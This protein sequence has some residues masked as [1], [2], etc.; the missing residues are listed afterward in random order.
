MAAMRKELAV[1][2]QNMAHRRLLEQQA[3]EDKVRK[4]KSKV[5]MDHLEMKINKQLLEEVDEFV[6]SNSL[7]LNDKQVASSR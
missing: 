4:T 7:A 3:Y 1:R 2:H 6:T 5:S